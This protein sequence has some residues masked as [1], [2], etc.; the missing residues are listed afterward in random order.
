M[1]LKLARYFIFVGVVMLAPAV[2]AQEFRIETEVYRDGESEPIAENLTLFSGNLIIDF[3]LAADRTRF[4]EEIVVYQSNEKRFVLLNTARQI[5]TEVIE[6]EVLK[7]LAA[8]Q[9]SSM[10][11]GDNE[12]L[13]HPNF[14]EHYDVS[15]GWLTMESPQLTYRTRGDRPTSN[16]LHR[17]YEF[18]DQFAR[19]NAT[20]PRRMPP[21]GRLKLNAAIKKYGFIPEEVEVTL[22]PQLDPPAEPIQ[23]RTRHAL[24]W[25]LSDKDQQRI[26]SAKRYWMDFRRV[27]LAEFRGLEQTADASSEDTKHK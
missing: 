20:D 13:F 8:L 9:S 7:I 21:F 3:L 12:F 15:S 14:R 23:L 26:E 25:E 2:V 1:D 11:S 6:G 17:I 16:Q 5:K 27:T 22:I 19:L 24:M 18:L 10:A 4:P